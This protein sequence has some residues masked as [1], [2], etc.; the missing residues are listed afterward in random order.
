MPGMRRVGAL[1]STL[2]P[3]AY[4]VVG[5]Q[6]DFGLQDHLQS[7]AVAF[8]VSLHA[9]ADYGAADRVVLRETG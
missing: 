6:G 5:G 3:A 7:P 1:L 9:R 4:R 8:R 2:F